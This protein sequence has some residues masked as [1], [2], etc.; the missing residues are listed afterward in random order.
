MNASWHVHV[1]V[2]MESMEFGV[3]HICVGHFVCPKRRSYA[4]FRICDRS[5]PVEFGCFIY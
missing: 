5:V 3:V 4:N 1:K 2:E